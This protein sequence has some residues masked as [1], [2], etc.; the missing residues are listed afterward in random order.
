MLRKAYLTGFSF[1]LFLTVAGYRDQNWTL[2]VLSLKTTRYRVSI[3]PRQTKV[4][5]DNIGIKQ[6]RA[7]D[8]GP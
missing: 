5:K 1:V 6:A 8:Q 7:K 4:H 3:D 2:P